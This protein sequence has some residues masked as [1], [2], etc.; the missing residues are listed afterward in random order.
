MNILVNGEKIEQAQIDTEAEQLRPHYEKFASDNDSEGSND[1]LLEWSRENII[2]RTLMRQEAARVIGNIPKQEIESEYKKAKHN[3][4]HMSKKEAKAD[5]KLQLQLDRLMKQIAD[6]APEA[7]EDDIKEYYKANKERFAAPEQVH[8]AHIE[9]HI[10]NETEKDLTYVEMLNLREEIK[11]GASFKEVAAANSDCANF[12]LGYFG[13]GQMVREFEDVILEMKPGEISDV[14][15]TPFGYHIA[16][17][18]DRK[19][20]GPV[21][22]DEAKDYIKERL[23]AE[24]HTKVLQDFVDKLKEK[25]EIID[26]Q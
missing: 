8:A 22:L 4:K 19:P 17:V 25:A 16:K 21:P 1:E 20:A 26:G 3:Y 10:R 5:I 15:L 2:E 6:S 23:E 14:F 7:T 18:Y 12:D 13:R 9:K 11:Q 24:K